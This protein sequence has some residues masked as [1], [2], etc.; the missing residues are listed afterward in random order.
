VLVPDDATE[1]ATMTGWHKIE[2]GWY[3]HD[4]GAIVQYWHVPPSCNGKSKSGWFAWAPDACISDYT[5]H[6]TMREAMAAAL[7][8]EAVQAPE[9]E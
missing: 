7:R 4:N 1:E 8:S 5:A 9:A 2:A 3:E 6:E